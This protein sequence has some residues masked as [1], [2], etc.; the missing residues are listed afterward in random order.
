MQVYSSELYFFLNRKGTDKSADKLNTTTAKLL[1]QAKSDLAK[2]DNPHK[3]KQLMAAI[4]ALE[5]LIPQE[6]LTAKQ[7][8]KAPNNKELQERLKELEDRIKNA[9]HDITS[10]PT[11]AALAAQKHQEDLR[12]LL[13]AA[14]TGNKNKV[15]EEIKAVPDAY[16]QVIK[17][18]RAEARET[19]NQHRKKLLFDAVD[20]LERAVP[21][22]Q[23]AARQLAAK[24]NDKALLEK[25]AALDDRINKALEKIAEPVFVSAVKEVE[26]LVDKLA[27]AATS[28]EPKVV[29]DVGQRLAKATA[30]LVNRSLGEASRIADPERKEKLLKAVA[31]L[32]LS[33]PQEVNISYN[34]L[35]NN[36]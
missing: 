7:L 29:A 1:A 5:K 28:G 12:R 8:A 9:L 4:E 16:A 30:D 34:C 10:S 31:D 17:E 33:V 22:Y 3:R 32:E 26:E 36:L 11:E 23:M 2:T 27:R 18:A 24:P 13:N 21:E 19:D 20:D 35:V 25:M 6:V 14:I 15:E